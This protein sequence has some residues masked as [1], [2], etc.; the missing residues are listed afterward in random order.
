MQSNKIIQKTTFYFFLLILLC[1]WVFPLLFLL[2]SSLKTR[3]DFFGNPALSLP[4]SWFWENFKEAWARGNMH[5][6]LKNG[7]IICGLKVPLGIL[8]EALA[9]FAITHLNIRH[10]NK[11]FM[12][13]LIGMMLPMQAALVPINL[14]MSRLNLTNTYFGLFYVYLGF[15]IP[16]GI[17][18][19]RG[20]FRSIPKEIDEAARIDGCTNWK[21]FWNVILPI[22][23]PAIATL[24]ILDFLSTWNEF[25][26]ASLLITEDKMRTVPAGLMNFFGDHGADYPLLSAG[27]LI[28]VIPIFIVYLVFQKY[29]V[30]GMSGA[31]KG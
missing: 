4:T 30:E 14:A 16:F 26:L 25:L 8:I 22:S 19:L 2:F 28:S 20:F 7:V 21:L 11:V 29:F 1:I 3:Q 12:I 13:F 17:L 24:V 27:V 31:V 15:G 10:S 5:T 9:A 23:K 6:Y 18:I